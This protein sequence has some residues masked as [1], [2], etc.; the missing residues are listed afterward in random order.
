MYGTGTRWASYD[1]SVFTGYA[2]TTAVRVVNQTRHVGIPGSRHARLVAGP[3][4]PGSRAGAVWRDLPDWTRALAYGGLAYTLVQACAHQPVHRRRRLLRL[5]A[6]ARA[7]RRGVTQP[8]PCR[9]PAHGKPGTTADRRPVARTS[10]RSSSSW[11]HRSSR[12]FVAADDVWTRQRVRQRGARSPSA[13]VCC[14][15]RVLVASLGGWLAR[16]RL[17]TNQTRSSAARPGH[18]RDRELPLGAVGPVSSRTVPPRSATRP[19][20]DSADAQPAL[21]RSGSRAGPRGCRAL[22][23]AR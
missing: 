8:S 1:G 13:I 2:Q 17:A 4:P 15:S 7:A 19:R 3:A 22:R 23:R 12:F 6:R 20:I 14:R 18:P 5:P 11:A 9:R 10:A 16:P 21:A